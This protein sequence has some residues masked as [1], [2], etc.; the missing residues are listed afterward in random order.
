MTHDVDVLRRYL[1]IVVFISAMGST[2]VPLIYA[3]SPWRTRAIG[4]MFMLQAVSFAVALDMT[5][6]FQFWM[7]SNILVLFWIETFVFTAIASSTIMLAWMMWRL[8][9]PSKKKGSKREAR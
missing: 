6:L 7:P 4:R 9:H 8:N 3:F 5:V 2:S 1:L